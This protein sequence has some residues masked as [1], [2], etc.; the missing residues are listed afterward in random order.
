[1]SK[2][3]IYLR[4]LVMSGD[5]VKIDYPL[6]SGRWYAFG[7]SPEEDLGR[8][9]RYT[10]ITA[11]KDYNRLR[12]R[13]NRIDQAATAVSKFHF[14]LRLENGTINLIP[15][16]SS[17]KTMVIPNN[18]RIPLDELTVGFMDEFVV[19]METR[20]FPGDLI[21]CEYLYNLEIGGPVDTD[22]ETSAETAFRK[23]DTG[24][25]QIPSELLRRK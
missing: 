4:D 2:K 19:Y 13:D 10:I 25:F 1:M 11:L 18:D 12:H 16:S 6:E 5:S 21:I 7:K 14:E 17:R 20:I 15:R 24:E 8:S 9:E 22:A 23:G 3:Q